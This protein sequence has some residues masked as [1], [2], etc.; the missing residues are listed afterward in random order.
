MPGIATAV[1]DRSRR[2]TVLPPRVRIAAARYD[3][4]GAEVNVNGA[5]PIS[6]SPGRPMRNVRYSR[7]QRPRSA[8]SVPS[9][10]G[11]KNRTA[12]SSKLSNGRG[13]APAKIP[14]LST[15]AR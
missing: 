12:R 6:R 5:V 15:S 10:F 9:R 3:T 7:S 14:S 11:L 13:S 8:G 2:A 1:P 4:T